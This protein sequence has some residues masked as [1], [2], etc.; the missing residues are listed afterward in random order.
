[1]KILALDLGDV[2]TGTAISDSLKMLARP[3]ETVKTKDLE[4]F[5]VDLFKKERISTVVVGHPKTL[6]GTDSDQTRTIVTM[7]EE[8]EKNFPLL[9]WVLWDERNSSKQAQAIGVPR[10]DKQ[11]IH[12]IAAAL[13]LETYLM[14]LEIRKMMAENVEEE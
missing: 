9:I 2:W 1:M 3:Y 11:K 10:N 8:L 5:L 12:S 7:K 14:H 13:V 6:R 4:T